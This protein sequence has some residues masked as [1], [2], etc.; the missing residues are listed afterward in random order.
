[1][2]FAQGKVHDRLH[3][4]TNNRSGNNVLNKLNPA[5]VLS[6]GPGG[7]GTVRALAR[8]GIAVTAIAYEATDPV[9]WSRYPTARH[10]ATGDS[11][12]AKETH[13]LRLLTDLRVE[14]AALISTSDQMVAMMSRNEVKLLNK[15]R[16]TLPNATMVE[17][18]N[19]KSQE[20]KLMESLGISIPRTVQEL[21]DD[22]RELSETLRFPII[23]KPRS[24][25]GEVHIFEKRPKA[26]TTRNH[27]TGSS[28]I[29]ALRCRICSRRKS[30]QVQM[31]IPGSAAVTFDRDSELLDCLVRQKL[32]T[33]PPHFGTSTYSIS[34]VNGEILELAREL[35]K[36]LDYVGHVGI[37]YRWDP[38]D[39][40]FKYIELN[41]RIGGEVGFD[42]AC[43]LPTVW[44]TYLISLGRRSTAFRQPPERRFVFPGCRPRHSIHA[45]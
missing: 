25:R 6:H 1:M 39:G 32:R 31:T 23:F 36:A 17:A 35:G 29:G 7:L 8:R 26:L 38:R 37:E 43:G 20:T 33:I 45:L 24:V 12:A 4:T 27:S 40:E 28:T 22:A 15:Y 13:I 42:E 18:L 3:I 41:P 34:R 30:S 14:D 11:A 9:L 10:I 2:H 5:V 44:N 16:F 19:D 21:P